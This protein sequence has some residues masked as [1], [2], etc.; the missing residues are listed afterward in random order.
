MNK[1]TKIL[2]PGRWIGVCMLILAT[3][4]VQMPTTLAA[5]RGTSEDSKERT[6]YI[7]LYVGGFETS[8]TAALLDRT[9]DSGSVGGGWGRQFSR[10]LTFEYD[11]NISETS[12]ELPQSMTRSHLT[13]LELTL[14]T[15]GFLGNVKLKR[16]VGRLRPQIGV[17]LGVGV[18]D[19]AMTDSDSW[20]TESLESEL[21]L[22]TQVLA[23]FDIR[24]TG[25]SYL[26]IEYRK[27]VAHRS[28]FLRDEEIDGGGESFVLAYRFAM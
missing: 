17:G 20:F 27:L 1:T 15:A 23:G 9:Q 8:E 21:S 11:L 19:V 22:L 26:G 6:G 7:F 16:P 3:C 13:D 4:A 12:Y 10:F 5:E 18:I 2:T 25:R 28:M 24:L 14:S